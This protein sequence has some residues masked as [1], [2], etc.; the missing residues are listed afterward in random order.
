MQ[1][2]LDCLHLPTAF[3]P[4]YLLNADL[5]LYLTGCSQSA[6]CQGSTSALALALSHPPTHMAT[7]MS[8]QMNHVHGIISHRSLPPPRRTHDTVCGQM[9]WDPP[10]WAECTTYIVCL[11]RDTFTRSEGIF[12]LSSAACCCCSVPA[13]AHAPPTHT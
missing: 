5:N 10:Q 1:S 4:L 3:L 8:H 9:P 6:W 7:S 11:A 2:S 12:M 13:Q